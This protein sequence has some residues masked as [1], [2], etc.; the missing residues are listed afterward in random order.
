[1]TC[2]ALICEDDTIFDVLYEPYQHDEWQTLVKKAVR[3]E[4][5]RVKGQRN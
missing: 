2:T 3:R 5:N 4:V 1:M